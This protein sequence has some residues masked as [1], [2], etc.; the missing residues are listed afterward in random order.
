MKAIVLKAPNDFAL[1]ELPMPVPR[2]GE[3]LIRV[4]SSPI[5]PSDIVFLKGLYGNK[6][7]YPVVPGFEGSGTVVSSGGGLLAWRLVGKRVA[8]ACERGNGTWAEFTVVPAKSC[9]PLTDEIPFTLGCSMFANPFTVMMFAE[10]IKEGKH[11]A[12]IQTAACSAVGK[13]LVRYCAQER[14]PLINIVR[15]DEQVDIL[16]AIGA[17]HVLNSANEGF[18]EELKKLSVNLNASIAFDCVS[19]EMTGILVN[20]MCENSVVYVYGS[21]SMQPVGHINPAALI[22]SGKRVEGLWLSKWI[23]QKSILGLWGLS[24]RVVAL[25]PTVLRTEV[26]KEFPLQE[27][28]EALNFYKHNMSLGKVIIRPGLI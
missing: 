20:S 7:P 19:G 22:F 25:L 26:A 28:N 23:K 3:V 24:N 1:E 5:N 13:M 8:M 27:L 4:D 12:V 6:K 9:V 2:S 17:E 10:V 15:R 21:L 18:E 16:R 14:I 11:T